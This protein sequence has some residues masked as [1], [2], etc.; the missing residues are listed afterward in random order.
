[1]KKLSM[2]FLTAIICTSA[3]IAQD[4][5][6]TMAH[7]PMGKHKM[8]H[9]N[10]MKE[11]CVMMKDSK[12]MVMKGGKTMAMDQ[13]MTLTNG[14]VVS[15]N[16]MVV[17]SDGK[18]KQLK[19]GDCVYMSGKMMTGMKGMHKKGMKSKTAVKETMPM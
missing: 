11:D 9:M 6:P 2:L 14:S 4:T 18:S 12:M 16:G 13:D 10:G 15:T 3:V 8:G 17:M 7:K 1:M 5:T 19:N